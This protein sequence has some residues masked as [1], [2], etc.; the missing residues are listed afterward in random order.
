MGGGVGAGAPGD[1]QDEDLARAIEASLRSA[2][3]NKPAPRADDDLSVWPFEDIVAATGMFA[4][5]RKLGEGGFGPVYQGHL[6]RQEVAIKVLSKEAYKNASARERKMLEDMFEAEV[7]TLGRF[8]H[9]NLVRLVG[10]SRGKAGEGNMAL[11]YELVPGGSLKDRLV[12]PPGKGALT[13]L[14]LLQR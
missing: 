7:Q 13:P 5:A 3:I 10:Y 14:T 9:P 12:P 4:A 1:D 8:R 11:V 6:A 2:S